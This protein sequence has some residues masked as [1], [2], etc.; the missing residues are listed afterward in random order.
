M[1]AQEPELSVLKW[2]H[3]QFN[4]FVI[5]SQE[6]KAC[7]VHAGERI[8]AFRKKLQVVPHDVLY[9]DTMYEYHHDLLCEATEASAEAS[10]VDGDWG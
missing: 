9:D 6:A 8:A 5:Q 1:G 7:M 4:P 10:S 2:R 3:R